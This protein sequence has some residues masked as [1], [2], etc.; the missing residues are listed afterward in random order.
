MPAI[1]S[2]EDEERWLNPDLPKADI[3]SL[4]KPYEANKMNAYIIERDFIKKVP[5]DSTILQRA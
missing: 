3:A 5:T 4:L 1:L 2:K